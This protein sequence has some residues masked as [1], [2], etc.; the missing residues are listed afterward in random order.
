MRP[1]IDEIDD[2]IARGV[3]IA[4]KVGATRIQL[5]HFSKRT[6]TQVAHSLARLKYRGVVRCSGRTRAAVWTMAPKSKRATAK[7]AK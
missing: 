3:W 5:I 7:G 6:A 4:G 1:N 2:E